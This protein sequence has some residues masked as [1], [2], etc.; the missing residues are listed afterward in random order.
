M[1]RSQM[2]K[3]IITMTIF[4]HL[5]EIIAALRKERKKQNKCK[6]QNKYVFELN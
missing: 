2:Q 1:H 4:D 6:L 5:I 3:K